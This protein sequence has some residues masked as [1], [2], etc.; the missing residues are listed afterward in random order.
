MLVSSVVF[1]LP[2]ISVMSIDATE[3]VVEHVSGD[4]RS[5]RLT[6]FNGRVEVNAAVDA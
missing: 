6:V 2:T 1:I 4:S 3:R 5:S